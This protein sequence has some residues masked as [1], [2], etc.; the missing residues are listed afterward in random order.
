MK[1]VSVNDDV[2]TVEL[3]VHDATI[4]NNGLNEIAH[5]VYLDEQEFATR[6]GTTKQELAAFL[7]EFNA[8]AKQLL[9]KTEKK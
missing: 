5:G 8:A 7:D 1:L 2:L 4:I 6:T 9:D 3:S